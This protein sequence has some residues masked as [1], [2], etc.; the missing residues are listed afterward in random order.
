M[1]YLHWRGFF[2]TDHKV[3]NFGSLTP[4]EEEGLLQ[5]IQYASAHPGP[6]VE[7]GS[8]FGFSTQLIALHKEPERKLLTV[9]NLSWNPLLLSKEEHRFI[10][11][12]NLRWA[13]SERNTEIVYE[14]LDAFYG[15]Y[16][17]QRPAMIFIDADHEY[18]GVKAD[19]EWAVAQEIPIICGHD[20]SAEFPGVVRAVEEFFSPDVELFGSFWIVRSS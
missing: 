19:I 7:V 11:E 13:C 6:I 18:E 15:E 20:F 8:L 3:E 9:D 14:D 1:T 16:S 4:N 10:L 2:P 17:G 5:A 12:R